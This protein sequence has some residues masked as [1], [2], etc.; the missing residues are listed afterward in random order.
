[1]TMRFGIRADS[2]KHMSR[3]HKCE[4]CELPDDLQIA[5]IRVFAV[6]TVKADMKNCQTAVTVT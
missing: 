2:F 5:D 3:K 6:I 1:M 4:L